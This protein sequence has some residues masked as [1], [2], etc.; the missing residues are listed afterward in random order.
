MKVLKEI[1]GIE[2]VSPVD[3]GLSCAIASFRVKN[4]TAAETADYLY[5]QRKI[6][7]VNRQLGEK[8]CVRV[9][10]AAYNSL[11]DIDRFVDAVKNGF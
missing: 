4:K 8:G 7:T 2:L 5:Q 9:T 6:F 10:P 3:P 1:P 11:N